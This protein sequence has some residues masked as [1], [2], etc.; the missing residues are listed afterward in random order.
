MNDKKEKI[1]SFFKN[2]GIYLVACLCLS[3]VGIA[4]YSAYSGVQNDLG[5][6]E[7]VTSSMPLVSEQEETEEVKDETEEIVSEI[8]Q[9]QPKKET[10][11]T[12]SETPKKVSAKPTDSFII[13]VH[14]D[15]LKKFSNEELSF[16]KTLN[17]LRLHPALDIAC[18]TG[19]E[20]NAAGNGKVLEIAKDNFSGEVIVIEHTS[21]IIIRY[22]GVKPNDN[23]KKGTA[24]TKDTVIGVST[25]IPFECEDEPHIHIE[26]LQNDEFISPEK[27]L[28]IEE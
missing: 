25:E 26:V 9:E 17:D 19:T 16:S 7:R 14:G 24:V 11:K 27:V 22:V 1:K 8:K 10:Q 15:I 12:P 23:I 13:P 6:K 20:V 18:E 5:V 21:G 3:A 2:K 28:G 4:A